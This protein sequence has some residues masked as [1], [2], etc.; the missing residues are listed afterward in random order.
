ML[1]ISC[2]NT[3]D[4]SYKNMMTSHKSNQ[5]FSLESELEQV[6]DNLYSEIKYINQEKTDNHKLEPQLLEL[7]KD[8]DVLTKKYETY[9]K[10]D[11]A[12]MFIGPTGCGKSTTIN[13]LL[14]HKMIEKHVVRSRS[15]SY[16]NEYSS[17]EEENSA[18]YQILIDTVQDYLGK[19]R[20]PKIGH[21]HVSCTVFPEVYK[22]EDLFLCD[23]PGFFDNRSD[24]KLILVTLANNSFVHNVKNL[25]AIV[26]ANTFNS[27]TDNRGR[28]FIEGSIKAINKVFSS[29]LVGNSMEKESDVVK[30]QS[31]LFESVFFLFT[32]CPQNISRSKIRNELISIKQCYEAN[33]HEAPNKYRAY[34]N[35]LVDMLNHS[36]NILYVNPLDE[37]QTKNTILKRFKASPGI[38]TSALGFLGSEQTYDIIKKIVS[39]AVLEIQHNLE[40]IPRIYDDFPKLEKDINESYSFL[41]ES[42]IGL[43]DLNTD[44]L[45]TEKDFLQ[46][47]YNLNFD[48]FTEYSDVTREQKESYIK[49]LN[50]SI[51]SISSEIAQKR[52]ILI[53]NGQTTNNCQCA[54]C[55]SRYSK[56]A[57]DTPEVVSLCNEEEKYNKKLKNLKTGVF[58]SDLEDIIR[59]RLELRIKNHYRTKGIINENRSKYQNIYN[60]QQNIVSKTISDTKT[61]IERNILLEKAK[62]NQIQESYNNIDRLRPILSLL[63]QIN[64]IISL[65]NISNYKET[66]EMLA[67]LDF[68]IQTMEI[69]IRKCDHNS[70]YNEFSDT[71]N[72]PQFELISDDDL[73]PTYDLE[74]EILKTQLLIKNKLR[75]EVD[76]SDTDSCWG[77]VSYIASYYCLGY[78]EKLEIEK[79]EKRIE[80]L[81]ELEDE[82]KSRTWIRKELIRS[83]KT[84]NN[85]KK[86]IKHQENEIES[87][88]KKL[89]ASKKLYDSVV[90]C[91]CICPSS[92]DEKKTQMIPKFLQEDIKTKE[93]ELA[94]EYNCFIDKESIIRNNHTKNLEYIIDSLSLRHDT[95]LKSKS[96]NES[97]LKFPYQSIKFCED[98]IS[99]KDDKIM[100]ILTIIKDSIEKNKNIKEDEYD[101]LWGYTIDMIDKR[102]FFNP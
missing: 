87:Y 21:G 91:T 89:A 90:Q 51:S 37:G 15:N 50:E 40:N 47:L 52:D 23:C 85:L 99:K 75:N 64:K 78:D 44:F 81:S 48:I 63:N 57:I 66:L 102:I 3:Y 27:L 34:I 4:G 69:P 5:D 58:P 35:F 100:L 20:Y 98:K 76:S 38:E 74:K 25:K 17:D 83:I 55:R 39:S 93:I 49:E 9:Y 54:S 1:F 95:Y 22:K 71:N 12:I 2:R 24:K 11:N 46:D 92:Y 42:I 36:S 65:E 41:I 60:S 43:I 101:L 67:N 73:D 53:R 13:Y 29:S 97:Q 31:D 61:T 14:G 84:E 10:V 70:L 96:C 18:E 33:L 16:Q 45:K 62:N 7:V 56:I 6:S 88:S 8:I 68:R 79:K 32:K 94:K 28:T 82:V 26:L 30:S 19:K 80:L 77:Y 59:K 86:L 72:D